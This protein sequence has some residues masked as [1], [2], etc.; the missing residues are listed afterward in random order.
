MEKILYFDYSAAVILVLLVASMWLRKMTKGRQNHYLLTV[1]GMSL[2][3][4]LADICAVQ[5]DNMGMGNV[6]GKY[7]SHTVYLL[8]HNWTM[9]IYILYLI[10]LT[11]TWHKIRNSLV[12]RIVLIDL[13][14]GLGS[15]NAYAEDMRRSFE[16]E[17]PV[18]LICII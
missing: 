14:T 2:V 5:L 17:K 4:V 8:L 10:S 16:N 18:K 11:D 9:P 1:I 12:L 15:L 7:I 3:V 6:L 13:E